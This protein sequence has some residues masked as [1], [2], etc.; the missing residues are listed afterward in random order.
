M[1][2]ISQK[3]I[4]FNE[5]ILFHTETILHNEINHFEKYFIMIS[6]GQSRIGLNPLALTF[7]EFM[8]TQ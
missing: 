7:A 1:N 3:P 6:K 5:T 4:I 2:S 8:L